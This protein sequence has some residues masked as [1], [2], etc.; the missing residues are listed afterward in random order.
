MR[1]APGT[2][3]QPAQQRDRPELTG[4]GHTIQPPPASPFRQR[5]Q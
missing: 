2:R 3:I 1:V 5:R 4:M